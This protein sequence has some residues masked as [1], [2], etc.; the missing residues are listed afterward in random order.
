MKKVLLLDIENI[1]KNENQLLAYI[2]QYAYV[3][4]VYAKSPT[5]FTL[6]AVIKLNQFI[7][8]GQLTIMKMPKIGKN[9]AD[10]GLSY[11][12]GKLSTRLSHKEYSFEI[13]SKDKALSYIADLLKMDG[14]SAEFIPEQP[15]KV[16]DKKPHCTPDRIAAPQLNFPNSAKK[17]CEYLKKQKQSRPNKLQTLMNSLKAV[18][19]QTDINIEQVLEDLKVMK[20]LQIKSSAVVYNESNISKVIK[21]DMPLE[22]ENRPVSNPMYS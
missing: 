6:D 13:M 12:A 3:Y 17:Y 18:L 2:A 21:A 9:S 11:L 1:P 15:V 5:G 16:I 20:V 7:S 8:T 10:F 14:F 4:I 19:K 22:K